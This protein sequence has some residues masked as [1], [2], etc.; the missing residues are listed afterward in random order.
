MVAGEDGYGA[1]F[2]IPEVLEVAG[3]FDGEVEVVLPDGDAD[4]TA[5][6]VGAAALPDVDGV[7]LPVTDVQMPFAPVV[8]VS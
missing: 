4:Q 3:V 5:A 7:G 1:D 2:S 6:L 8:F